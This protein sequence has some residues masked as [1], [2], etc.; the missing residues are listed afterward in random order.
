MKN[1]LFFA[2][3]NGAIIQPESEVCMVRPITNNRPDGARYEVVYQKSTS[4]LIKRSK[5]VLARNV[6]FSAGTLGTLRL[7]FRCREITKTLPKISPHLGDMV[8]T[9]SESLLGVSARD[10]TTDYSKGIAITSIF[11][12][13][14]LTNVEP[15]RYPAGSSL[16]RFLTGPLISSSGNMATRFFKTIGIMLRRPRDFLRSHILPGWARRTTILLV[17]QTDDNRLK[18]RLGRGVYTLG[19]KSL[20][21]VTDRDHPIPKMIDIGHQITRKMANKINGIPA[22]SIFEALL[23]TPLTAHILGGCPIGLDSEEG[24]VDLNCQ[25]HNYPG[26]FVVDGSIMPANPGVNPS[27]TITALAEYAMSQIPT[28]TGME[29]RKPIGI[30]EL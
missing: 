30:K 19:T 9:N 18:M 8:R 3:K 29:A 14:E 12:P 17:M 22:G 25:V 26:L 15:V 20:V 16:M 6:I 10:L 2:E 4:W 13:D 21:T 5:R 7:L 1:Y 24:V 27:L 28:K 11:Q 23:N